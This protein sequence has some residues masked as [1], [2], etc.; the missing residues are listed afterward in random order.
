MNVLEFLVNIMAPVEM[1][2]VDIPVSACLDSPVR[3][4]KQVKKC[5]ASDWAGP[6]DLR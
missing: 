2:L 6:F 5:N 1:E 4:V 3:I